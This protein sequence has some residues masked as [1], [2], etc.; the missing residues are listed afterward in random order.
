MIIALNTKADQD[1]EITNN[2]EKPVRVKQK[3]GA[4]LDIAARGG[5]K[6]ARPKKG[7]VKKKKKKASKKKA[8]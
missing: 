7:S 2:G 4:D 5:K 8:R 1:I 3:D 6:K